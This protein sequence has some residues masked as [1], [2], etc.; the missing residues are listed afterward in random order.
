MDD[1]Y[2]ANGLFREDVVIFVAEGIMS[3]R[4]DGSVDEAIVKLAD[5]AVTRGV[6]LVEMAR[7]IVADEIDPSSNTLAPLPAEE[8]M[9]DPESD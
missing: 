9:A 3:E 2:S 1:K 4:L 8:Q 6:R 5:M 7:C